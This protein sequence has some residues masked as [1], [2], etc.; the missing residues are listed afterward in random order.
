M[1]SSLWEIQ[2]RKKLI[3]SS[4]EMYKNVL[5]RKRT[6]LIFQGAVQIVYHLLKENPLRAQVVWRGQVDGGRELVQ[7]KHS[8]PETN[9]QRFGRKCEKASKRHWPIWDGVIQ[10]PCSEWVRSERVGEGEVSKGCC[11][12]I[13]SDPEA[14]RWGWE[15]GSGIV[16]PNSGF[17]LALSNIQ[18]PSQL[19][20]LY[21]EW[22]G[23]L[24]SKSLLVPGNEY[25][26]CL[27]GAW[28][29]GKKTRKVSF[30]S[31]AHIPPT[32]VE[33]GD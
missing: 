7:R 23:H 8:S 26:W 3:A 11:G 6:Q 18:G 32:I 33:K 21:K 25:F 27:K 30:P 1:W 9:W 17:P 22:I 28:R 12:R 10:K 29:I 2:K 16:Y 15:A 5:K 4:T 31:A 14:K 20:K 19:S 13:Q 24:C